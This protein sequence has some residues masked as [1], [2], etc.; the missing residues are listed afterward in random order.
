M[1]LIFDGKCGFAPENQHKVLYFA[2][3]APFW[4]DL[5]R[6][7]VELESRV[8]SVYIYTIYTW[9]SVYRVWSDFWGVY[10]V[11]VYTGF[12]G[13]VY[14]VEILKLEDFESKILSKCSKIKGNPSQNV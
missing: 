5:L 3:F 11:R 6:K 7:T 9:K 2:S 12:R 1:F 14:R 10:R 8:I 4:P 13:G